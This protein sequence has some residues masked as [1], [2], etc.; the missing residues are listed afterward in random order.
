MTGEGVPPC[1]ICHAKPGEKC[2]PGVHGSHDAR[3]VRETFWGGNPD[4][5]ESFIPTGFV[6]RAE[7][8]ER[9]AKL[10]RDAKRTR[11]VVGIAV[12]ANLFLAVAQ[13]IA[14]VRYTQAADVLLDALQAL[15]TLSA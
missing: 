1:T 2:D 7:Y 3:R 5:V 10:E 14:I 6:R 15:S 12:L 8:E 4:P 9:V 11:R 13:S